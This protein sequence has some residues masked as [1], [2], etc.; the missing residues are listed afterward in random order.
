MSQKEVSRG[1]RICSP[2]TNKAYVFY[3]DSLV[4]AVQMLEHLLSTHIWFTAWS[5]IGRMRPIFRH[6]GHL[7]IFG[8]AA[9]PLWQVAVVVI[10]TWWRE[11][12]EVFV[13][14]AQVGGATIAD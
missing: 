7:V 9:E 10:S 1:S 14:E 4:V 8:V 13:R 12:D 2:A 6:P 5:G 11:I 3:C